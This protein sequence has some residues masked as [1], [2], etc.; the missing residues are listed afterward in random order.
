MPND[1]RPGYA[2][3]VDTSV[4]VIEAYLPGARQRNSTWYGRLLDEVH[5][6]IRPYHLEVS[7][8]V[9]PN[10]ET[11]LW[12]VRPVESRMG[13]RS[14]APDFDASVAI[15]AAMASAGGQVVQRHLDGRLFDGSGRRSSVTD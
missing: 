12:L 13:P 7:L 10:D 5:A 11:A 2:R 1:G 14:P 3:V 4:T 8:L 9:L 15:A 6:S